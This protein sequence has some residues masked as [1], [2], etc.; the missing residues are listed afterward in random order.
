MILK[1]LESKRFL[2]MNINHFN[3]INDNSG[4]INKP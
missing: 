4:A 3:L 2:A 1:T